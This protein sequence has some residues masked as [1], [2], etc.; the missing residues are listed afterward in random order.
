MIN[1]EYLP[2]IEY[3][4]NLSR[5]E[6]TINWNNRERRLIMR[7]PKE[8]QYVHTTSSIN[9]AIIEEFGG[10]ASFFTSVW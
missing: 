9:R 5:F 2:I 10:A 8:L 7:I 1:K 4:G 6:D 3:T